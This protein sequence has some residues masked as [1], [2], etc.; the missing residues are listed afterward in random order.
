MFQPLFFTY[1]G[2]VS[3]S[4]FQYQKAGE[5]GEGG[6][7]LKLQNL[8]WNI[9]GVII[10]DY[11]VWGQEANPVADKSEYISEGYALRKS[12]KELKYKKQKKKTECL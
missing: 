7:L 2:S 9:I 1:T 6:T 11:L 12:P 5:G 4:Y 8:H 10:S 3:I